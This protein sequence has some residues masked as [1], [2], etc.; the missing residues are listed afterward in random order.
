ML[1]IDMHLAV[2]SFTAIQQPEKYCESIINI[3]NRRE[4]EEEEKKCCSEYT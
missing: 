4:E 3:S 1:L 2:I